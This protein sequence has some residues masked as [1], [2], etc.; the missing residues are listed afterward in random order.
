VERNQARDRRVAQELADAG[1]RVVVVWE[2]E[3][4]DESLLEDRLLRLFPRG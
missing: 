4:G 3:A 1:W 2:C